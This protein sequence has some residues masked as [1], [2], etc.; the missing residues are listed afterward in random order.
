MQLD[1]T[2]AN[3]G[4]L[5]I[6]TALASER[7]AEF[8]RLRE[9]TS[10]TDGNLASHARRLNQAGLIEIDKAF[11]DGKPVTSYILT[12][13]GLKALEDHARGILQSVTA[14]ILTPQPTVSDSEETWI[15]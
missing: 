5:M 6:L 11:R 3:P 1:S 4:R 12:G 8:V 13:A 2:V 10:L 7:R 9:I 15:D 14:P